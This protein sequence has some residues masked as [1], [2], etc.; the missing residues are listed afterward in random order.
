MPN[1]P[2]YGPARVATNLDRDQ[3]NLLASH[4]IYGVGQ[5][6]LRDDMLVCI[7]IS[8][9]YTGFFI[10]RSMRQSQHLLIL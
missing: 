9:L 3:A 4:G 1:L 5:F 6:K 8:H 7:Y 2:I 10:C